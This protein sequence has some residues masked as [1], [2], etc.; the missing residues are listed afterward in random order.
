MILG[1]AQSMAFII[2]GILL[3]I[4][5]TRILVIVHK[6]TRKVQELEHRMKAMEKIES[7]EADKE[8]ER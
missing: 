1:T 7:F 8:T 4:I 3:V 5:L 2:V 6:Q